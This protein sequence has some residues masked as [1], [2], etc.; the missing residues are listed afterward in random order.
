MIT[1]HFDNNGSPHIEGVL[2]LP[3]LQVQGSLHFLMD[4]GAFGSSIMPSDGSDI[5]ID[6]SQLTG[7][8]ITIHGVSGSIKAV[9]EQ[10]SLFFTEDTGT[11][12]LYRINIC[13]MPNRRTLRGLP[14]LIGQD[15]LSRWRTGH[16][17]T[18]DRLH[19]SVRS[20]DRTIRP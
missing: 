16:D 15:I 14:S 17:P 19:A 12:R 11:V 2:V 8:E 4:T 20:A 18:G 6:Y 7:E 3:G 13:I 9:M 5:G 1:G 10:A